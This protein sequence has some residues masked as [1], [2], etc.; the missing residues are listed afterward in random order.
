MAKY[1][2]FRTLLEASATSDYAKPEYGDT[3]ETAST[4]T[5]VRFHDTISVATT[6]STYSMALLAT[7]RL[8]Q[9][10]NTDST[11][12]VTL[13]YTTGAGGATA[14]SMKLLA[15]ETAVLRDLRAVATVVAN[16]TITANTAACLC[17]ISYEGT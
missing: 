10:K 3:E 7:C 6:G 16:V 11:N 17:E 9:I 8:L 2:R 1:T 4:S 14:Q 5:Q 15:G 12:Y 13:S